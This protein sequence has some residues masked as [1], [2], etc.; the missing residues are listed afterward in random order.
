MG[1]NIPALVGGKVI[2]VFKNNKTAGNGVVIRGEDG[3]EYRYIHMKEAPPVKIGQN[4]SAGQL[5]GHVGST[6]QSSGAHLDLKIKDAKGNYVD[7]ISILNALAGM[8]TSKSAS[9]TVPE[10]KLRNIYG[11]DAPIRSTKQTSY[12]NT[13]KTQKEA[14]K[15][16]GYQTYKQNLSAALKTGKI[17][18]NWVV[19]L[20]EL[21]GRESGWNPHADNPTSSAYGYGQF[22]SSTRSSY[23]K[24]LG[25]S[26]NNPVHQLIMTA[27]YIKDRYGT[28]EKAL[29][30]WDKHNYY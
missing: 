12:T 16:R 9:S 3:R 4:V 27:Q 24:K 13:W 28:P 20:T 17:P 25:L 1:M 8:K 23:E 2:Q 18:S 30:F 21:I 19:G 15:S 11:A 5:L 29:A 26:Y 10:G 22:L 7:P 6:G 14:L